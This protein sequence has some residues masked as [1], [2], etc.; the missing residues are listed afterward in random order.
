MQV[1]RNERRSLAG[2]AQAVSTV[3]FAW[4]EPRVAAGIAERLGPGWTA[5]L[6]DSAIEI[7]RA[8]LDREAEQRPQV[9][10]DDRERRP[11]HE[12]ALRVA[13]VEAAS[14]TCVLPAGR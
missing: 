14:P 11:H 10:G 5:S 13:D 7:D 8:G 6:H 1:R 3:S 2:T 12:V 4:L 9:D